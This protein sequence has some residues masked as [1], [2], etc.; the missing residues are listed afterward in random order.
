V[1]VVQEMKRMAAKKSSARGGALAM[2]HKLSPAMTVRG[3]E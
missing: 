2:V 1:A 3:I